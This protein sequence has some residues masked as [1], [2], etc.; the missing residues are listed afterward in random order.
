MRIERHMTA[1]GDY[2][3]NIDKRMNSTCT[4]CTFNMFFYQG[5][6]VRCTYC[7]YGRIFFVTIYKRK[8]QK[9]CGTTNQLS[10]NVCL[11]NEAIQRHFF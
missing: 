11:L 2:L 6:K 9:P 5:F 4:N 8:E 1:G 10:Y 3:S 7:K